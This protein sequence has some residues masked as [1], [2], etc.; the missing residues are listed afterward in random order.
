MNLLQIGRNGW[1]LW[2]GAGAA[3]LVAA[4]LWVTQDAWVDIYRIAIGDEEAS[5]IFLVP[6]VVAWLIWVRLVRIRYCRPGPAL[7]GPVLIACGWAMATFGYYHAVQSFWHG[8]SVLVVVGC[9]LTVI[10]RD[11]FFKFLPAFIVLVFLVPV[12]NMARQKIAIPLQMATAYVT[13]WVFELGGLDVERSGN[14]LSCN[15]V[16]VAIA[17]ACNGM[18]MVFA[19]VLVSFAFAFGSPLRNYIRM[20]ILAASPVSAI[21]CNVIRLLPTVWLYGYY[22]SEVANN[23]HDY[24]GWVMLPIA[25]LLLMGAIRIMR[26]ALMPISQYTLAYD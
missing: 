9:F 20:L 23:F 16:D 8:G 13:Q 5:H 7:L 15:G 11:V 1:S 19:L 4:G 14:V 18:R 6:F 12:P 17:E 2:H 24:S 22:P 10:G 3:A 26:W 25:F 21:F